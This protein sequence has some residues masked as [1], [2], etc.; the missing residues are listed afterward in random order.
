M[1]EVLELTSLV[2]A[3]VTSGLLAG[4]FVLYAHT[5][6]PALRRA[7]DAAFVATFA[8]LDRAIVNPWFMATGFL[9]APL[10]TLL[11]AALYAGS[12]TVWWI[13][14]ALFLHVVMVVV[15][16]VVH[17]PRN[18]ALKVA[19]GAREP[20]DAARAGFDEQ[21]WVRWNMLRVLT[22]TGALGLLCWA[23]VVAGTHR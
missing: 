23:L 11:A 12:S 2:A 6:M 21:R 14:A 19:A 18:D 16:A 22:S 20:V 13:L 8:L 4:V 10:L 17:L 7:D 15:T 9:G 5:V 3:T 1:S